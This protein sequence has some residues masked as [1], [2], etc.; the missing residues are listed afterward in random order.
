MTTKLQRKYALVDGD[1][2]KNPVVGDIVV[3]EVLGYD[4]FGYEYPKLGPWRRVEFETDEQSGRTI[5]DNWLLERMVIIP[6]SEIRPLR[7]DNGRTC[8]CGGFNTAGDADIRTIY[9]L[10]KLHQHHE[11]VLCRWGRQDLNFAEADGFIQLFSTYDDLLEWESID[12][13]SE[14]W[15]TER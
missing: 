11:M 4:T 13:N 10:D 8:E 7:C 14:D 6:T 2:H 15:S 3:D 5:I 1:V 12:L 9:V